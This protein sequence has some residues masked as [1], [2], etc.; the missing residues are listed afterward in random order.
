M[1]IAGPVS[2][3]IEPSWIWGTLAEDTDEKG[4]SIAGNVGVYFGPQRLRGFWL[5]GQFA[6]EAFTAT[7][8]APDGV[9]SVS[10]DVASPVFGV[11]LGNNFVLGPDRG[12]DGGF[13]VSLGGGVGVAAGERV[14]LEAVSQ[15]GRAANE[16]RYYDGIGRVRP[17]GNVALGATF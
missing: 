14:V 7:L 5:K 15:G 10:A 11:M 2:L 4:L 9:A 8:I 1:A 6:Y 13:V 3:E 12:R 17:L 16:I